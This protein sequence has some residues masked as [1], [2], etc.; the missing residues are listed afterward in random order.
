M[1]NLRSYKET[2]YNYNYVVVM[3]AFD[4]NRIEACEPFR[5]K[6]AAEN[7]NLKQFDGNGDVL[8]LRQAAGKY[9]DYFKY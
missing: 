1:R 6:N 2:G 9:P 8:T 5:T 7:Y 3:I 4:E